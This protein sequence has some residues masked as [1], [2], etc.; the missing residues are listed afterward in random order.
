MSILLC[1]V[2]I[3]FLLIFYNIV[4]NKKILKNVGVMITL[5]LINWI[6]VTIC[7]EIKIDSTTLALILIIIFSFVMCKTDNKKMGLCIV[8]FIMGYYLLIFSKFIVFMFEYLLDKISGQGLNDIKII[9]MLITIFTILLIVTYKIFVKNNISIENKIIDYKEI[10]IV[11]INILIITLLVKYFYSHLMITIEIL[12][13]ILFILI[14]NLYFTYIILKK[15]KN[16]K[17]LEYQYNYNPII[18]ELIA[19]LRAKEHEYKNHLNMLYALVQVSNPKD[20]KNKVMEYVGQVNSEDT[21][22][23]LLRIDNSIIKAVLYS[24]VIEAEKKEYNFQYE[25]TSELENTN[26]TQDE[27]TVILSNLINNA[28]ESVEKCDNKYVEL[29]IEEDDDEE[30]IEIK[31]TVSGLQEEDLDKIFKRGVSSK[32]KNRGFGLY[33]IKNIVEKHKG[34]IQPYLEH[35][36]LIITITFP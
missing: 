17:F 4:V 19:N 14:I 35:D 12:L 23:K 29:I 7:S 25:I 10:S 13:F 36:I 31:N 2:E 8:V 20:I 33:N 27:I 3:T 32:G 5:F 11:L 21:L 34:I 6:G 28:F 22:N 26:L 15:Y 18:D 9:L 30:I 24:K 1:N 16:M